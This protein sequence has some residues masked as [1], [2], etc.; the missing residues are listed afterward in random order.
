MFLLF[1]FQVV[2]Y[3]FEFIVFWCSNVVRVPPF[4]SGVVRVLSFSSGSFSGFLLGLGLLSRLL[5]FAWAS[6]TAVRASRSSA[7]MVCCSFMSLQ[8]NHR[9]I[10]LLVTDELPLTY[11]MDEAIFIF[12]GTGCNFFNLFFR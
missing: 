8:I 5:A 7:A 9:N 1:M 3:T 2:I 4:S 10:N 12:R 11:K 6:L